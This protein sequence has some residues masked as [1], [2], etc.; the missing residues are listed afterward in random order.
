MY[1]TLRSLHFFRG[2]AWFW[3]VQ[4]PLSLA[5]VSM[6][7]LCTSHIRHTNHTH[8]NGEKST[9]NVHTI[10]CHLLQAAV[11]GT[12][13]RSNILTW[14]SYWSWLTE[15]HGKSWKATGNY[16]NV[17]IERQFQEHSH[18]L[19]CK[20]SQGMPASLWPP[21]SAP[22]CETLVR[23]YPFTYSRCAGKKNKQSQVPIQQQNTYTMKGKISMLQI[24]NDQIWVFVVRVNSA[25]SMVSVRLRWCGFWLKS[26]HC[27]SGSISSY[28]SKCRWAEG[29]S[30][31]GTNSDEVAVSKTW[32]VS[33]SG[34]PAGIKRISLS[35]WNEN[36]QF[37]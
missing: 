28:N 15:F 29:L 26:Y 8:Q 27:F 34:V 5:P 2:H 4:S 19:P 36:W 13:Q 31:D 22:S 14:D 1:S 32:G 21:N 37:H 12:I 11:G 35:S 33:F 3:K 10:P 30:S 25:P 24:A 7:W 17:L 20:G 6:A 9:A 18:C 23:V 16:S